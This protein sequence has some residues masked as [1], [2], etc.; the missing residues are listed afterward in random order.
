[1]TLPAD[2]LQQFKRYRRVEGVSTCRP[3]RGKT[4]TAKVF[5]GKSVCPDIQAVMMSLLLLFVSQERNRMFG[6]KKAASHQKPDRGGHM[7]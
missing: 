6:K 1:M 4:V 3:G 5:E 7:H 2:G